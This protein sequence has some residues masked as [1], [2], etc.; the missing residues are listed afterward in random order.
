MNRVEKLSGRFL[1]PF[2]RVT[3]RFSDEAE[4]GLEQGDSGDAGGLRAQDAWSEMH[5]RET[6]GA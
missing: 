4:S 5:E 2:R 3:A 1:E 6:G